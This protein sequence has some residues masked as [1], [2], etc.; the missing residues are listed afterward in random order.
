MPTVRLSVKPALIDWACE[1]SG[2]AQD[3]LEQ[4]FADL[5]KWRNGEKDPTER[6]LRNFAKATFTPFGHFFGD[7]PPSDDLPIDDF[8]VRGGGAPSSPSPHL[9]DTIYLCQRQQAWYVDHLTAIGE[10]ELNW[11]GSEKVGNDPSA[12]ARRFAGLADLG[13]E[14]R[15]NARSWEEALRDVRE[16]AEAAGVLVMVNGIVGNNTHRTLDRDEFSGFALANPLAPLVFINNADYK[17]SQMFTFAHEFGHLLLGESGVSDDSV[18]VEGAPGNETWCDRFAAELLVPADDLVRETGA[19][20]T[21]LGDDLQ[22][23][24]RHYK[25][26]RLVILRRLRTAEL[27]SAAEYRRLFERERAGFEAW[28][29][30]QLEQSSGGGNFYNTFFQRTGRSFAYAVVASTLEGQTGYKEM[31]D[32]LGISSLDTFN[33]IAVEL[34]VLRS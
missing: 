23:L 18:G 10:P 27:I 13:V 3:V 30:A 25:V 6:Q 15:A 28:H 29:S 19:S 32:L 12:A 17:A 34:G 1:R 22:R 9:L 20:R 24:A 8:R 33:K 16:R 7:A 2:L 26:S 14:T 5:P 11:V 31:S 4:K 21:A